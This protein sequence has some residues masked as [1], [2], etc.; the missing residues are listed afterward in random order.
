MGHD[1]YRRRRKDHKEYEESESLAESESNSR[2]L[3]KQWYE[4]TG[5]DTM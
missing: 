5:R 4:E 3:R 1:D 2:H